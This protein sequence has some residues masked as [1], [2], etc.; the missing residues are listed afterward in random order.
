MARY[1]GKDDTRERTM[2]R[3][4]LTTLA[5]VAGLALNS[6]TEAQASFAVSH[7]WDVTCAVDA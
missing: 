1:N 6:Q 7:T 5:I 3:I 2:I 4:I